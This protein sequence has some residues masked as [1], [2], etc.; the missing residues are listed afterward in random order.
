MENTSDSNKE[1]RITVLKRG[2]VG[3]HKAVTAFKTPVDPSEYIWKYGK[4]T[5][6]TDTG[7]FKFGD[8]EIQLRPSDKVYKI[9]KLLVRASGN[10]FT[11]EKLQSI[12][13]VLMIS[14]KSFI[15]HSLD[16]V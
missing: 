2:V 9:V 10:E 6:N 11:L 16:C 1:H 13:S 7:L 12:F 14:S 5:L 4:I 15:A 8:K 3:T